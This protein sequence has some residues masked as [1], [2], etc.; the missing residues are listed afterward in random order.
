MSSQ[1]S[2][3][4]TLVV[5]QKPVFKRQ[6]TRKGTFSCWECKNRKIRCEFKP[7]S[8]SEC[9]SCQRRGLRCISQDFIEIDSNSCENIG[10]RIEYVEDLVGQLI[11]ERS[12]WNPPD[13]YT[14]SPSIS[15]PGQQLLNQSC[16]LS[17]H[18]ES[19]LPSRAIIINLI[20][21]CKFFQLPFHTFRQP[22]EKLKS[23][24]ITKEQLD[25]AVQPPPSTAPPV[26]FAQR[27]INFALCLQHLDKIS[28][29]KMQTFL[30]ASTTDAAQ[31]CVEIASRYVTS[32]DTLMESLEGLETYMLE[33]GY[34]ISTGNP[35]AA[36]LLMRRALGVARRMN[37]PFMAKGEYRAE[38]MWFRLHASDRLIS[39]MVAL[40]CNSCDD[41]FAKEK[42]LSEK[43]PCERLERIHTAIIGRIIDRNINMQRQSSRGFAYYHGYDDYAVTQAIDSEMKQAAKSVPLEWWVIPTLDN[44]T[45]D[46]DIME[47]T[48]ILHTQTHQ[49]YILVLLHQPYLFRTS[50][51]QS[52]ISSISSD[53][54]GLIDHAYSKSAALS[55]SRELLCRFLI[56]RSF[57]HVPSYRGV[58]HKAFTAAVTLILAHLDGHRL[59]SVNVLQ[60]QRP[61]DLG[62]IYSIINRFSED[63]SSQKFA[64][65][66]RELLGIEADASSGAC[67]YFTWS[68]NGHGTEQNDDLKLEIPY[69]G[70]L[71]IIKS[72]TDMENMQSYSP[73]KQRGNLQNNTVQHNLHLDASTSENPLSLD[74]SIQFSDYILPN[75]NFQNTL[76]SLPA[77][78]DFRNTTKLDTNPVQ[79][80]VDPSES[81][82]PGLDSTLFSALV[83]DGEIN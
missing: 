37:L 73:K 8:G 14:Y 72:G 2:P 12:N 71:S 74:P 69:F 26:I 45:A 28:I 39:L 35:R 9:N 59:S 62:L 82:V 31:R 32:H 68:E 81:S 3:P 38:Y 13:G 64:H 30:N 7:N 50:D 49:H 42:I 61:H 17:N 20:Q 18:L 75:L 44:R 55:A 79:S 53:T 78:D 57:H 11:R 19:L 4:T 47:R 80:F 77:L 76:P 41:S 43:L 10:R 56:L 5:A 40:P 1:F 29:Q 58:D 54:S 33:A 67:Y 23:S 52:T 21:L 60:H 6:K 34:H 70:T 27:L 65:T 16:S 25:Q 24:Q 83:H 15:S 22:Y 63:T 48:A 66:L 46:V 36:W 51:T